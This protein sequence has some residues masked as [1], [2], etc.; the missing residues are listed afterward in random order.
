[1]EKILEEITKLTEEWRKLIS[2]DHCKDRDFHFYIETKWSYGKSPTYIVQHYGYILD[3]IQ[4]EFK[5]YEEALQEL[6]KFLEDSI[7]EE[8][9][10][11]YE[12][13]F[14]YLSG[15]YNRTNNL[16]E[17]NHICFNYFAMEFS[18]EE[19]IINFLKNIILYRI[20]DF[21]CRLY[22]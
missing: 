18:N 13:G 2:K 4:E 7:E 5:T 19:R 22:Q 20:F 16:N 10:Y 14:K 15:G 3:S 9:K 17:L 21:Y 1:M 12:Y 6:K 8:K 11:K